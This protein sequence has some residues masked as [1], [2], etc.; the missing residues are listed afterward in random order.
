MVMNRKELAPGIFVYSDVIENFNT[1]CSDI[2]EGMV[3]AR[4]EWSP[5]SIKSGETVKIDTDYRDTMAITVPYNE[6]I[7]ENYSN[8]SEAFSLSLSNIF[9][10]AFR[11]AEFD[12][13]SEHNLETTWHDGYSILKYGKGQKFTNH[14][15]DHKDY[16][17]RM[18][19]VYYINDD[20]TGGEI[21]FP[22]FGITYK[23][24]AN[25]LLIFPSTYVYNHS[26]LPV[27]EGIRYAVVSWL[28]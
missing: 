3:S 28:R 5:S 2:E 15:D 6:N 12:Y 18:S 11:P 21:R 7:I 19:L 13:K 20:Y 4:M 1:L 17:R 10:S 14:V 24:K 27:T 23:P 22:R 16:H 8:L 26:V 25:E 9:L